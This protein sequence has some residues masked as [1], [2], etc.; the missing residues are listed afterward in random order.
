MASFAARR[1][2]RT[3][4]Q[5]RCSPETGWRDPQPPEIGVRRPPGRSAPGD[6]RPH[7]CRLIS[8]PDR[9]RGP[10]RPLGRPSTAATSRS[11]SMASSSSTF[12]P[13][14]SALTPDCGGGAAFRGHV[15]A[16][17]ALD[18]VSSWRSDAGRCGPRAFFR[19]L[20][21]WSLCELHAVGCDRRLVGTTGRDA[22]CSTAMTTSPRPQSSP[23]FLAPSTTFHSH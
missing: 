7:A 20:A 14:A 15:F 21:V 22:H 17:R 4:C 18:G 3:A 12:S 2:P 19:A 13:A 8:P 5:A 6:Q 9:P 23:A 16:M 1:S 10:P 11:T